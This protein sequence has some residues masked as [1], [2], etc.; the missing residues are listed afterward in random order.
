MGASMPLKKFITKRPRMSLSILATV[1]VGASLVVTQVQANI[2]TQSNNLPLNPHQIPVELNAGSSFIDQVLDPIKLEAQG[3]L[4]E[5]K[6]ELPNRDDESIH[7]TAFQGK[8]AVESPTY[9]YTTG[10]S[11]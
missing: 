2:Q 3:L 5:A 4:V 11:N 8:E 7:A 9:D 1:C 10:S 6:N